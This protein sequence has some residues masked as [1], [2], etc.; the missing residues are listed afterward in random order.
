[1]D[2]P[3]QRF[4]AFT[5]VSRVKSIGSKPRFAPF[6]AIRQTTAANLAAVPVA[7]LTLETE[8][9]LFVS[10]SRMTSTQ[11]KLAGQSSL[12]RKSSSTNQWVRSILKV[13]FKSESR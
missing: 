3:T 5:V 8:K 11:A 4:L 12:A 9:C 10:T 13:W 7:V 6:P 1:M 2:V